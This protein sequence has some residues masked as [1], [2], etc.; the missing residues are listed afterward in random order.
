M[1]DCYCEPVANAV[2][3]RP[4]SQDQC[5]KWL[6]HQDPF[7]QSWVL[8]NQ[9]TAK[10]ASVCL[11]P[12]P[13]GQLREVLL[14]VNDADDFWAY[15]ALPNQL[16]PGSYTISE[17]DLIHFQN[18]QLKRAALAWGLGFYQFSTY[19]KKNIYEARLVLPQQINQSE[20]QEWVRSIYLIRDLIN[21]PTEDL[22]PGDLAEV[23]SEV[24]EK[25][26]AETTIIVGDQLLEQNY[27]VIH[28]VGRGSARPPQLID[29][30]W[31]DVN[32]PKLTLVGKGVCFDAGGLDLKT[33]AGMRFM[34]K[35]M[36]GAAHALGLARMVMSQQLPIRLRVLIPA[37][38][39]TLSGNSYRP[40]DVLHTRSGKT[41]EVGNTDAEG[42]LILCDALAE[43]I[44]EKPQLLIDFATLT[45]PFTLGP[46]LP[47]LFCNDDPLAEKLLASAEKVQDPI[48]RMPLYQPYHHHLKS[49][50]ADLNNVST[51]RYAGSI[52]AALF[53]QTFVPDDIPWVHFDFTAWHF[54]ATPGRPMG[55]D[56]LA[57]RGVYDYL[58][59][60]GLN[61]V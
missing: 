50:I 23:V 35:D 13:D 40:G 56:T 28:A 20:L 33:P 47:A 44:T 17:V 59:N 52:T 31:G 11:V 22:G 42:R 8:A 34:K 54:K 12:N 4:V 6:E 14:G 29:L 9:F 61:N 7:L 1:L 25:Y 10:S 3:I 5:P 21:T 30:R 2:V 39:N 43:A 27:P 19:R 37:V 32:A 41:V 55:G 49:E 46:D 48:W 45:G 16:P 24:G 36:A 53:L 60:R 18:D 57:L 15:A 51:V 58:I 38:E 26:S